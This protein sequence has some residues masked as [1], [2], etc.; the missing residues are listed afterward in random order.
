[1]TQ[2]LEKASPSPFQ[3]MA[4]GLLVPSAQTWNSRVPRVDAVHG[5]GEIERLAVLDDVGVVEDAVPAVEPAVG[6]PRQRVGQLV[7][8]EAAEAGDDDLALVGLAG[9]LRVLEEKDV[10]RVGDPD[11][12]VAEVEAGGDV[13]A[14]GEDRDLVELAVAVRVFEDLDT[15]LTRPGGEARVFDALG[16]PEAAA[17]VEGHGDGVHDVRLA[18]DQLDG[19]AVGHGHLFDGVGRRQRRAGHLVLAVRDRLD[20][21]RRAGA[22][23]P[24]V[25]GSTAQQAAARA[26]RRRRPATA[27]SFA[28]PSLPCATDGG[29]GG[30]RG[31]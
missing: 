8:V 19:E 25:A 2:A 26:R 16:D 13:E 28:S 31:L 27:T 6:A 18:G 5:A 7:R 14:V 11:A 23:A 10:G 12:A 15:I 24:G 22:S 1:M 20:S 3:V 21:L 30:R 29:R 9:P 4:H 17:L